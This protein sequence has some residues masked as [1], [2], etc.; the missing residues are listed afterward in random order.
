MKLLKPDKSR[1]FA[2][3]HHKR[4]H[5]QQANPKVDTAA[6]RLARALGHKV[7]C[8]CGAEFSAVVQ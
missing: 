1:K 8:P 6:K 3:R 5:E 7:T 2:D 4:Y